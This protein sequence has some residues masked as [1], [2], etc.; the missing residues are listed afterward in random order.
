MNVSEDN[1][2]EYIST[3]F[4]TLHEVA[5]KLLPKENIP[6]L[7]HVAILPAQ[8]TGYVSTQYGVAIEYH[9]ATETTI[10]TQRS[11][12]RIEDLFVGAPSRLRGIGPLLNFKN[13]QNIQFE[14][15]TFSDAFPFRMEGQDASVKFKPESV[16]HLAAS[17]DCGRF[18]QKIRDSGPG[19]ARNAIN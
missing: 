15:L 19:W 8:I 10:E 12:Q 17:R 4:D 9:P 2:K 1:L 5:K 3:F 16:K 6:E 11:S 18:F 13:S 7:F 14:N